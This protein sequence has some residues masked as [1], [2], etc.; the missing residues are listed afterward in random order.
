MKRAIGWLLAAALACSLLGCDGG[1]DDA[2]RTT[3]DVSAGTMQEESAVPVRKD[4]DITWQK[5]FRSTSYPEG[6]LMDDEVAFAKK[7]NDIF[8]VENLTQNELI[9][10][11]DEGYLPRYSLLHAQ[12]SEKQDLVPACISYALLHGCDRFVLP[13]NTENSRLLQGSELLQGK[14]R[15]YWWSMDIDCDINKANSKVLD[16]GSTVFYCLVVLNPPLYRVKLNEWNEQHEPAFEAAKQIVAQMPEDCV[17]DYDKVL[18]LYNYLTENVRYAYDDEYLDG[19]DYYTHAKNLYYDTLI[20]HKT[21]CAGYGRT[22]AWL[23]ELAGLEAFPV[24][25]QYGAT[26]SHL[27][28]MV[29]IDDGYYWF[30]PTWDEGVFPERYHYF[31]I[32]DEQMEERGGSREMY[33]AYEELLPECPQSLP[34]PPVSGL[35]FS[36]GTVSGR[37]YRNE[38]FGLMCKMPSGWVFLDDT[39][40]GQGDGEKVTPFETLLT[41][42]DSAY[43]MYAFS[44]SGDELSVEVYRWGDARGDATVFADQLQESFEVVFE[45]LTTER[46]EVSFCGQTCQ[47]FLV[48]FTADE[49]TASMRF[50]IVPIDGALLLIYSFGSDPERCM[51][52]LDYFTAIEE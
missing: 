15:A 12:E 21:V 16:D 27:W 17:S 46:A 29:K 35:N 13:V 45:G 44:Y 22:F 41:G 11:D 2:Q 37:T 52:L 5:A 18:Y 31:G 48:V 14:D 10:F 3:Q 36:R 8:V 23:C 9:G 49:Y 51:Q 39:Q 33:Q 1:K 28:T 43:D 50:V 6:G 30:D 42:R 26:S 32:S 19:E 20:N 24:S 4:Y 38:S 40:I 25:G 34:L 7:Q 47:S